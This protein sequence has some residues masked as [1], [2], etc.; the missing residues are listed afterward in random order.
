MLGHNAQNIQF[1][2]VAHHIGNKGHQWRR[3][4]G[5]GKAVVHAYRSHDQLAVFGAFLLQTGMGLQNTHPHLPVV[6]RFSVTKGVVAQ[7]L[8]KTPHIVV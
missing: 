7:E 6:A 3:V 4:C 8:L 1:V 2:R 5:Q